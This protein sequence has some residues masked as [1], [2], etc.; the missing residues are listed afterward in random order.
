MRMADTLRDRLEQDIVTSA[1]PPGDTAGG[2]EFGCALRR[3]ADA[4]PRGAA[5]NLPRQGW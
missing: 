1:L 4:N 5:C 3:L 2:A